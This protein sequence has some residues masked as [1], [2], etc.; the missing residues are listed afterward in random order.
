MMKKA[1]L[2]SLCLLMLLAFTECAVPEKAT[3]QKAFEGKVVYVITYD[4]L[5]E[6][7]EEFAAMMPSESVLYI[8]NHLSRSEQSVGMGASQV[9]IT[10]SKKKTAV[11][12]MDMMGQKLMTKVGKAY[13]KEIEKKKPKIELLDETKEIAGYTCKKAELTVDSSG[14]PIII[15]YTDEIPNR[16]DA[17]F[18]GMDGFPLEYELSNEGMV[19]TFSAKEVVKIKVP[20][21]LFTIPNGYQEVDM[22]NLGK[23]LGGGL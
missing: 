14:N 17:P 1:L 11:L 2:N 21:E 22:D 19:I 8:K 12:L 3:A 7:M 15:Y 10:D 23:M 18:N 9:T 16:M 20:D 13:F 5:P 6:G 4:N